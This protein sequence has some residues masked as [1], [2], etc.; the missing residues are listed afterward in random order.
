MV[1]GNNELFGEDPRLK[2]AGTSAVSV[3]TA[4]WP[5]AS[6]VVGYRE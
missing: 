3:N 2:K 6:K 1:H 5:F 4:I